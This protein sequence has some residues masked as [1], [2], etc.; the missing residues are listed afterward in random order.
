MSRSNELRLRQV[1]AEMP[2]IM[3]TDLPT[4]IAREINSSYTSLCAGGAEDGLVVVCSSGTAEDL[5]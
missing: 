4:E 3:A 2:A 5:A 1:V